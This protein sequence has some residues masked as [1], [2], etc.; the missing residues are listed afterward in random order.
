[1]NPDADTADVTPETDW[2]DATVIW[3]TAEGVR[4]FTETSDL[5]DGPIAAGR[6]FATALFPAPETN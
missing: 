3:F 4:M 5:G 1:M 6:I 2:L